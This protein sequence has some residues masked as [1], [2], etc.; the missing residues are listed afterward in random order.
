MK[1]ITVNLSNQVKLSTDYSYTSGREFFIKYGENNTLPNDLVKL[2]NESPTHQSLLKLKSTLTAGNGLS[3]TKENTNLTDFIT[4]TDLNETLEKI[5]FDQVLFGGF[6]LQIIWS[7]DGKTIADIKHLD[8][9][10]VRAANSASP[11]EYYISPCWKDYRR[12]NNTPKA[13][14]IFNPENSKTQPIQILYYYSYYPSAYWYPV[15]DYRS[16]IQYI[17]LE[18]QISNFHLNNVNNGLVPSGLWCINEMPNDEER[19]QIKANIKKD[20][21]GTSNAGKFV[22]V[23]SQNKESAPTFTPIV[24]DNN[25]DIY[26]ALNEIT[27]Q[28]IVSGHKLNSPS[29]AGLPSNGSI[30][31]NEI[32]T[33]F[34]YF[35]NTIIKGYQKPILKIINRLLK[36]NNLIDEPV[37][38]ASLNPIQFKFSENVLLKTLT[39]NEF[40][41]EMG[42]I[43]LPDGDTIPGIGAGANGINQPQTI[44]PNGHKDQSN[45]YDIIKK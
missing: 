4:Y 37:T 34:E 30:F 12:P 13:I 33:A 26:N 8:F 35:N 3:Y 29:L 28:K 44:I 45:P 1:L 25:A 2:S 40:R 19:E 17:Q 32:S 23:F 11:Q 21:G 36:Q 22:V 42:K 16:S 27:V 43:P 20:F 41:T 10:T 31:T 15:E 9:S 5:S 39:T 7:R 6:A 24:T 18:S 38:I 14:P